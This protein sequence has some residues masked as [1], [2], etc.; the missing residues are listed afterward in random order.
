MK[1]SVIYNVE[2]MGN[3]IGMTFDLKEA[4][5]WA[6]DTMSH[7]VTIRAVKYRM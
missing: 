5:A 4:Q 1:K 2:V 7:S 6:R 3:S